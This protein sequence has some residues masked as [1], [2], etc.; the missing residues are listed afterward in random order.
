MKMKIHRKMKRKQMRLLNKRRME[1]IISRKQMKMMKKKK[2]E[3]MNLMK[4]FS[5]TKRWVI[6]KTR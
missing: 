3:L 2:M 6:Q 4:T 5:R 1:L